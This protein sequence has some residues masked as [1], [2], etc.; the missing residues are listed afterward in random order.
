MITE[1]L[2]FS[3]LAIDLA[4]TYISNDDRDQ[5]QA[6]QQYLADYTRQQDHLLQSEYY[7]GVSASKETVWTVWNM[8]FL[9]IEER[10]VILRPGLV[11]AFLARF[12]GSIIE[13]EL[14]RLASLD[15]P[16]VCKSLYGGA[17]V[18]PSWLHRMLS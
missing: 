9:K 10:H 3:A 12:K 13:D 18:L 8:T 17:E 16:N 15:M 4:E 7:C 14:F 11:L 2:G 6:L 1:R 5:R